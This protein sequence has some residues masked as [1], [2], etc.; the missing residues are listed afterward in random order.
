MKYIPTLPD[1]Y[2]MIS[3]L[4]A[5]GMGEVFLV[6]DKQR[7]QQIAMKILGRKH[8]SLQTQRMFNREF[9]ILSKLEHKN[10]VKAFEFGRISD[11]ELFYTMEYLTSD[12]LTT[13]IK[14][15]HSSTRNPDWTIT[16]TQVLLQL[17][18]A[19][20]HVHS[21]GVLHQDVKPD[22]IF[23][24]HT[25]EAVSVKLFDLGIAFYK[26]F[27]TVEDREAGSLHYQSPEHA[28]GLV[29][30]YSAD[31]YLF[32]AVAFEIFTGIKPFEFKET[33]EIS[34]P[35]YV[36][37]AVTFMHALRDV[38]KMK[39]LEKGFEKAINEMVQ[40]CMEKEPANRFQSM[41]E[42]EEYL[43]DILSGGLR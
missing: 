5:G 3:S 6:F 20:R 41:Y 38:P 31:I 19:I 18:H 17:A 23:I 9:E 7:G 15:L 16:A 24:S 33:D 26:E 25:P 11:R 22:N 34:G 37:R 29:L 13:W 4:A 21:I 28:K 27:Q 14:H 8:S 2:E 1:R 12:S 35:L 36:S 43:E 32:G 10:I 42:I 39:S 30:D 40:I